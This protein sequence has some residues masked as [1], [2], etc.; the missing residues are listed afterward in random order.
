MA[1][2]YIYIDDG[3][4][5]YP[6]D[7]KAKHIGCVRVGFKRIDRREW[8]VY[9]STKLDGYGVKFYSDHGGIKIY[10][11][12]SGAKH[13]AETIFQCFLKELGLK[14]QK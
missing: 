12:K 3:W 8:V 4:I 10:K 7:E 2:K 6:P 11:S 1:H 14:C 9:F 5:N 13:K